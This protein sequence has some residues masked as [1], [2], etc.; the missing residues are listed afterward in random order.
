MK[1]QQGESDNTKSP[2]AN[3]L[4]RKRS[5]GDLSQKALSKESPQ[6]PFGKP[7]NLINGEDIL[8][9]LGI[10]SQENKTSNDFAKQPGF[11]VLRELSRQGSKAGGSKDVYV[12]QEIENTLLHYISVDSSRQSDKTKEQDYKLLDL[13]SLNV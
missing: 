3:T 12:K 1:G 2:P 5:G 10:E 6:S 4:W 9:E 8:E 11:G 13:F 7:R